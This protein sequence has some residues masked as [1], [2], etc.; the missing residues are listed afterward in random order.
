MHDSRQQVINVFG[1]PIPRLYVAGELGSV[2]GHLYLSAGNLSECFIGGRV[3]GRE[4]A[5]QVPQ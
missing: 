2:F 5:A 1:E 3:A 4:A